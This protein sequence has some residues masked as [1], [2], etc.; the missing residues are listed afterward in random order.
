MAAPTLRRMRR[1]R[2]L[3]ALLAF[4]ALPGL[5]AFVVPLVVAWPFELREFRLFA[6]VPLV[7]GIG[8]LLWCVRDFYVAGEG[9][10][11]PWDPP[12]HLVVGGPYRVSRNPM[13]LAVV[14]I[15][16]GWAIGF[17]SRWL[18]LYA[19]AMMV[20][21][22]LR[23]LLH[24]EPFLARTQRQQW[25]RY[26]ARVPRWLFPNRKTLLVTLAALA[27][28]IPAAGLIYE[29]YVEG[30]A[31]R[32]FAPPGMLVDIGGRR[33]HL[34]CIGRGDPTVLFEASGWGVSSLSAAMVRERVSSRARVC[35]YDRM[36]M[37]WSDP[38]PSVVTAGE[39]AR[40]LAVLQDRAG[41]NGPFILVGSSVGGLTIEMFGRRYPERT[42][43]LV[44]LDAASSGRLP[45]VERYFG[46][47]R[48]TAPLGALAAR[49]GVIRLLDPLKI[50]TDTDEGRRS[51]AMT[52]AAEP[53]AA[54]SAITRGL[55]D[56]E[57]EFAEAPPLRGDLPLAVLSA[58]EDMTPPPGLGFVA[59]ILRSSRIEVH[60][61]L[62][63]QSTQGTWQMVP[64]STHL[65]ASSQPEAVVDVIFGMLAARDRAA[66]KSAEPQGR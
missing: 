39:L 63:K 33:V 61:Q 56:T 35:S 26:A 2:L 47:A 55:R 8:L 16:V 6:L 23:V 24:E 66:E 45:L 49:L 51:S 34:L 38:G 3:R 25:P 4:L 37:G 22:H 5:V 10:L 42:A 14:L 13:Y 7:A 31:A 18:L 44:F 59:S 65:I 58:S 41:L 28:L 20:V 30:L 48:L 12:R 46:V 29:S 9:T 15:L 64:K 1:T 11:A 32:E 36:G 60:K 21:F 17:R 43:G 40:Q 50:P 19:L 27:V 52:Y 62:A 53:I 57:R 54:L